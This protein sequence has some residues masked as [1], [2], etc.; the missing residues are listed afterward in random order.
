MQLSME[1]LIKQLKQ[2]YP[3]GAGGRD[4]KINITSV[5]FF[6]N[7]THFISNQILYVGYASELLPNLSLEE[8][9]PMICIE[10]IPV[11][12][13]YRTAKNML[14]LPPKTELNAVNDAIVELFREEALEKE[15]ME[16][17]YQ[18]VFREEDIGKTCDLAKRFIQN[19]IVVLDNSLKHIAESSNTDLKD[20]IWIDQRKNGS[21]ISADYIQLLTEQK[22][23]QTDSYS[24][25]PIILPK[26]KL[27]N[28]RIVSH[29]FLNYRPIGTIVVFEVER[30]FKEL[31]LK[32][33]KVL[34]EVLA[35]NMRNNKFLLYSKGIV[36]EH[37]FRDLLEGSISNS[38][39]QERLHSQ[40][41][42]IDEDIY[43][44]VVDI[45]EFD[46][47]YKTLQYFRNA[48]DD[49]IE[50]GK[51][52]LYENYCVII[53]MRK[54]GVYLSAKEINNLNNFCKKQKFSAGISKCFHDIA[55]L[56]NG[57]VQAVTAF[58]LNR[59]REREHQLSSYVDYTLEHI[60]TIA[61]EQADLKQFCE[62]SLLK[63]L[64]YDSVNQ[65]DFADCLHEFLSQER[66]LAHTALALHI[67]RNTLIYR[68]NKI[69]E[70]LEHD[71]E[72]PNYRFRLLLSFHI[73]EQFKN[74]NY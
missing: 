32:L 50:N 9:I 15:F 53:V 37:L 14:H 29:I 49:I 68:V 67:H 56:R 54:K 65:T 33:V 25:S 18:S 20:V 70:I 24:V 40:N 26:G 45:S 71:L 34:A 46:Q 13:E 4:D 57:F 61:S 12:E 48:L 64:E 69:Q 41:L 21:F 44:I 55:L 51:S 17:L 6:T 62:E 43:V 74:R 30:K 72:D 16:A 28:R 1:Q 60:L 10:D 22:G 3:Q 73:L 42:H 5:C 63:L 38:V 39:L 19:P 27:K 8:Q 66:N 31:D 23:Y 35:V 58:N 11:P 7:L 47:T 59:D 52:I 36:Y 2:F